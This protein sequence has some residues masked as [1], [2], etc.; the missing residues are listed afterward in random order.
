VEGLK[1][2]MGG[3]WLMDFTITANGQTDAVHF[4]MLLK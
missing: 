4:N 1:F 3:W 2:Q